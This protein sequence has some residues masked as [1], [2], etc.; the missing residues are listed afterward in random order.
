VLLV[1][2]GSVDLRGLHKCSDRSGTDTDCYCFAKSDLREGWV[3][4]LG[5][6]VRDCTGCE[7]VLRHGGSNAGLEA[8]EK[9]G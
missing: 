1:C 3:V 2:K 6:R 9:V 5:I 4:G 7:V 8:D